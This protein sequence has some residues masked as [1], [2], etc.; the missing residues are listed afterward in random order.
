MMCGTMLT[1]LESTLYLCLEIGISAFISMCFRPNEE[2]IVYFLLLS[3]K[4][5]QPSVEDEA[6]APGGSNLKGT[7]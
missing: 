3:R 4:E 6:R 2:K 1:F 5:R 7:G